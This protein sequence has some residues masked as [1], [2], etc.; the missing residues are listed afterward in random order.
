MFFFRVLLPL[1]F[2]TL[3]GLGIAWYVTKD[4]KYLVYAWRV[5]QGVLLLVVAFGLVYV[6][7]R[8]LLL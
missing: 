5:A 7:E 1:L 4:R 6:F 3:A 2:L 8:V